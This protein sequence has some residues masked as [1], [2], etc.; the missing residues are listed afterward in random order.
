MIGSVD[1][2]IE[3]TA[4]RSMHGTPSNLGPEPYN[5]GNQTLTEE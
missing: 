4:S 5:N 2:E 1:E 3:D